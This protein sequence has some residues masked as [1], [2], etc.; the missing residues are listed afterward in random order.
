MTFDE[1][2][3]R[4]PVRLNPS[5]VRMDIRLHVYPSGNGYLIA[6]EDGQFNQP[7]NNL[8]EALNAVRELWCRGMREAAREDQP[9]T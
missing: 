8:D 7:V 5:G 2:V 1:W 3:Q 9:I 6:N 4:F